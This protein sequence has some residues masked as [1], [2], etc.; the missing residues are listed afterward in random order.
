MLEEIV[1]IGELGFIFSI[2][3]LYGLIFIVYWVLWKIHKNE[4]L[5]KKLNPSEKEKPEAQ[6]EKVIDKLN[7]FIEIDKYLFQKLDG[8]YNNF[9]FTRIVPILNEF[10]SIT[11]DNRK[12]LREE[13]IEKFDFSI[14]AEERIIF[15]KR[16]PEF[17]KFKYIIIE[18]FNI[19]TTKLELFTI[20]KFDIRNNEFQDE[21][22][23]KSIFDRISSGDIKEMSTILDTINK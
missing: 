5:I 22:I 21:L 7:E 10:S 11:V 4:Q 8:L 2:F 1:K 18:Y 23:L 19:K 6:K 20:N 9:L 14:T 12:K 16:Y 17:E 3:A 15:Q 13:F